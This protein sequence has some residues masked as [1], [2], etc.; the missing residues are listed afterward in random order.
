MWLWKPGGTHLSFDVFGRV[1]GYAEAADVDQFRAAADQ[2]AATAR[3][4][5][6]TMIEEISS[7]AG[8]VTFMESPERGGRISYPDLN[9]GIARGLCRE[10]DTAERLLNEFIIRAETFE[11]PSP[12]TPWGRPLVRELGTPGFEEA[13]KERVVQRRADLKLE[14]APVA[15]EG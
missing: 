5:S 9:R 15:F 1:D 12:F 13:V 2:L 14:P 7:P 11:T 8:A 4:Q 10:W 6:L 3:D